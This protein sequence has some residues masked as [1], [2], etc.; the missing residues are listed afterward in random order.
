M[1]V[2][3][4]GTGNVATVLGRKIAQAGHEIVEVVGRNREA[5]QQLALVLNAPGSANI[6]TINRTSEVYLIAVS[7]DAIPVIAG[8]L[9]LGSRLVVHTAGSVSKEVLKNCSENYGVIYPLQTLKKEAEALPVIPLLIDGNNRQAAVSISRLL[10][11]WSDNVTVMNDSDRLKLHVAAVVMNNFTNHLLS[12][13]KQYCD[14]EGLEFNLLYPLIDQT[15]EQLKDNN[16]DKL[17]TGPAV[18]GDVSTIEKHLSILESHH[19]FRRLYDFMSNSIA[20]YYN[21][22]TGINN[23]A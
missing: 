23:K 9:S 6:G 13:T 11:N 17:Q 7:D 1:K 4:I 3:I 21:G 20:D 10:A 14:A 5:A 22:E 12:L 2:T 19:S 8:Q 15:V 18:R 16:P